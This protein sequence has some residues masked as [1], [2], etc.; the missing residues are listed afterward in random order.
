MSLL[1]S[2][3]LFFNY[4]ALPS[5]EGWIPDHARDD[6]LR[7]DVD[8]SRLPGPILAF[9]QAGYSWQ[10]AVVNICTQFIIPGVIWYPAFKAWERMVIEKEGTGA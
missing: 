8:N 5:L 6:E 9:L 4:H 1:V 3:S 2:G 10:A 7:T